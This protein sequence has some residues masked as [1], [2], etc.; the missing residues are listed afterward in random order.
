[1]PRNNEQSSQS[2]ERLRRLQAMTWATTALISASVALFASFYGYTTL[3]DQK[4]P[5]YVQSI[6][7]TLKEIQESQKETQDEL[8]RQRS[9]LDRISKALEEQRTPNQ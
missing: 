5:E 4:P 6:E 8:A 9:Q 2:V 1:M 7:L 3:R